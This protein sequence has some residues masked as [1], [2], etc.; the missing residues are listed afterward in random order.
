[1]LFFY[2]LPEA[3]DSGGNPME[4]KF[5]DYLDAN[6]VI[7]A[8][9]DMD[10]VKKCCER[11]EI[12]IVFIL[13]GDVCSICRIVEELKAHGKVAMVHMDLVSGL[14]GKEV[15]VDFIKKNTRADGI[16]STKPALIKR[17]RELDLYT[18]L[19]VFVLDSMAFENIEKQMGLARPDSI[20]ILPGLM[21]KVIRRVARLVKVPVIA[22]GA[23]LGKGG[24]DGR[25]VSRGDLS[26]QHK[27]VCLVRIGVKES[28]GGGYRK[29][30]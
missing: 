9:K 19:R 13:F 28:A 22:G 5:Y 17:A 27:P 30:Y 14:S 4:M 18:T 11:E 12:K 21:P 8:V 25:S 10:G 29:G 26:V 24:R 20:E 15:A 23:D 2:H 16:I 6:P 7:A 1:M 3:A